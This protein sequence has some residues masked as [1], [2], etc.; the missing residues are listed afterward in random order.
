MI[1]RGE[2]GWVDVG[3]ALMASKSGGLSA[4]VLF[5]ALTCEGTRSSL[6]TGRRFRPSHP[7]S[8][9]LA[10]TDVN[11]L[12]IRLMT[13]SFHAQ[14]ILPGVYIL[15]PVIEGGIKC[16][17]LLLRPRSYPSGQVSASGSLFQDE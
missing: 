10:P 3:R 8:T 2:G 17:C 5:P 16:R 15:N 12:F 9:T 6:P 4:R 14:G 13:G 7:H 11:R 1:R